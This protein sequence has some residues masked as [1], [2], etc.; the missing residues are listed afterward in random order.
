[1]TP[2]YNLREQTNA[3]PCATVIP[4]LASYGNLNDPLLLLVLPSTEPTQHTTF[5]SPASASP[6]PRSVTPQENSTNL[7]P[8]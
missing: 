2:I 3:G 1:M 6:T 8:V 7:I 5:Q 4:T